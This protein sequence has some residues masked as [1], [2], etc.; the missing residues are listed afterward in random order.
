M[1]SS[2]EE[3]KSPGLGDMSDVEES[4][5]E[6]QTQ[7]PGWKHL[8]DALETVEDEEELK[9]WI[10]GPLFA[11][12][13][14]EFYDRFILP[15]KKGN[16]GARH[17]D[18]KT[19]TKAISEAARDSSRRY[20]RS[21]IDT[22]D[23]S[24]VDHAARFILRV[25][26]EN[27]EDRDGISFQKAWSLGYRQQVIW[28]VYRKVNQEHA[29]SRISRSESILEILRY[30]DDKL[31]K[32]ADGGLALL[33]KLKGRVRQPNTTEAGNSPSYDDGRGHLRKDSSG[34][35]FNQPHNSDTTME[36]T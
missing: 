33:S 28:A 32:L 2:D 26:N 19:V 8:V 21:D 22:S 3:R 10:G 35:L 27:T 23:W 20:T 18:L 13:W 11:P 30:S 16:G 15:S 31:Q 12:A 9:G 6:F 34:P 24:F 25:V 17:D 14:F 29:K 5:N 7:G 1:E 36:G 4:E